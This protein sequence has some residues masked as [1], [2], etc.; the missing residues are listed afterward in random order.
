MSAIE[1][2]AD[3]E[4]DELLQQVH[5]GEL[6]IVDSRL[7][8]RQDTSEELLVVVSDPPQPRIHLPLHRGCSGRCQEL[9]SNCGCSH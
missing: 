9:S 5:L 6:D 1:D 7:N 8:E 3:T 2:I 4:F